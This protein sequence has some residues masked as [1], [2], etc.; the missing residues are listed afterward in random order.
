[1]NYIVFD[2]EWNQGNTQTTVPAIPFEIL[3]IGAVKLN[4][5]FE[6]VDTFQILV[7]PKIYKVMNYQTHK[8]VPLDIAQLEKS[9]V[10]FEVAVRRFLD[11]CGTSYRFCT[12]SNMDLMELQR[13]MDYYNI[14]VPF[15]TPVFYYDIQK[16]YGIQMAGTKGLTAL[17]EA[18]FELGIPPSGQFHRALGDA[19]YT[20][21]IMKRLDE[22]LLKQN[23]S[24]DCYYHPKSKDEQIDVKYPGRHLFISRE[25]PDKEVLMKDKEIRSTY[26]CKCGKS[27]KRKVRWYS[28]NNNVY[29][30]LVHCQEHGAIVGRIRLHKTEEHRF[31][32]EKVLKLASKEEAQRVVERRDEIRKRRREKRHRLK[33]QNMP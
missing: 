17:E 1:M 16:C 15:K 28:S 27:V 12:W 24:V 3:E 23:I 31:Y 22:R 4:E 14:P 6:E 29:F 20:A 11:W 13:N 30:C 2:L 9:G 32:A 26:C 21:K 7:C 25:F 10:D 33:G 5:Q 18:A 8:V 19:K